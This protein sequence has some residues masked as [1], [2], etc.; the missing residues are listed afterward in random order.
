MA[1]IDT[2][3]VR[4]GRRGGHRQPTYSS[5]TL[6]NENASSR[7]PASPR[8]RPA[9]NGALRAPTA[10]RRPIPTALPSRLPD[11]EVCRCAMTAAISTATTRPVAA[12]PRR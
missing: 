4:V 5:V 9:A 10:A 7:S 6:S 11:R 8:S 2:A 1:E 3:A 12:Q